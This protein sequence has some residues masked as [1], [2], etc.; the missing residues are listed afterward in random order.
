[1]ENNRTYLTK[2]I[3]SIIQKVDSSISTIV[4]IKNNED[5]QENV[6]MIVGIQLSFEEYTLNI[7]N[8]AHISFKDKEL[9]DLIGLKVVMVSE[10]KEEAEL[11]FDDGC[12]LIIN[13][14]DEAYEGPEAMSLYGPNDFWVV[15]N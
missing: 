11:C 7:Y 8:P 4:K 14:R 9:K 1:M 15:W 12:K 3:G 13:I 10:T 6:K 5:D 2:L